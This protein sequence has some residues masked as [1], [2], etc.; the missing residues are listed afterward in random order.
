VN[1]RVHDWTPVRGRPTQEQDAFLA[2][3]PSAMTSGCATRLREG[4]TRITALLSRPKLVCKWYRQVGSR[5]KLRALWRE[6]DVCTEFDNTLRASRLH[7]P[8]PRPFFAAERRTLGILRGELIAFEFIPDS[9]GLDRL[10]DPR[11]PG[12]A[13]PRSEK[14]RLGML[15]KYGALLASLHKAGVAHQ[16]LHADNVLVQRTGDED[17]LW[18]LDW[19]H[20]DFSADP[21]T[22]Q[23]DVAGAGADLLG[24][25]VTGREMLRW[26]A[27][28]CEAMAWQRRKRREMERR[29]LQQVRARIRRLTERTRNH[30]LETSRRTVR[31][32]YDEWF[33]VCAGK[34]DPDRV[35]S[36]FAEHA[37]VD[38][39]IHLTA[40]PL[41]GV[42]I[43]HDP[44]ASSTWRAARVCER[45]R[46]PC[47][48]V[49]AMASALDSES[50]WLAMGSSEGRALEKEL[51]DS[52]SREAALRDVSILGR[53]LHFYGIR[54]H[55]C[56]E[57]D[58]R[59]VS[60]QSPA[61]DRRTGGLT[62]HNPTIL[63][64]EP[65]T[66]AEASWRVLSAHRRKE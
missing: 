65:A 16:D 7:L 55:A 49:I 13:A 45:F 48:R 46:L 11:A 14:E 1:G 62:V 52:G 50:G 32:D 12:E 56:T 58:L 3:V 34:T 61:R 31:R 39:G 9:I 20:A 41:E 44:F 26:F 64:A 47:R 15:Y 60:I 5:A 36:T 22:R 30:A 63:R 59:R 43:V 42:E 51:Q 66:P 17:R 6:A 38:F 24:V 53:L 33:L 40:P 21:A 8:A 29:L 4:N 10:L 19:L 54:F 57:S 27:A 35:A 18:L 25:G 23:R 37:G 2:D 28:Y